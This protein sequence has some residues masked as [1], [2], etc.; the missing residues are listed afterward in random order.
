MSNPGRPPRPVPFQGDLR[1]LP[2]ALA[3]LKKLPNWVCWRWAWRIDKKGVGTWTKPPLQPKNRTSHARNNDPATWGTYAEALAVFET[4]KCDGIGFNLPGTDIAAFDIDKCRDPAT[5]DI[6]PEAMAIVNRATSYT[7]MTVSGTGLRVIGYGTGPKV[8]RKQKLPGSAVEV[9]SYRNAERYIVITGNP[10]PATWPHI[11]D[12][13]DVIDA[14]VAE[15]DGCKDGIDLDGEFAFKPQA[16]NGAAGD[17][18]DAFLPGDLIELIEKGVPP[19]DDLSAAFHHAV[20]WLADCGW[21]ADRIE[22][23]IAGKPIVPERFANRLGQE[24]ARCLH[25][26]KIKAEAEAKAKTKP[27]SSTPNQGPQGAGGQG[28]QQA[29]PQSGKGNSGAASSGGSCG[30][31]IDDFYAYMPDHSYIFVPTRELWPASSVNSRL[32]AVAVLKEDGTPALDKDGKP[33]HARPSVWLDNHR[34]VE[35][36][37]WMPG[38]PLTIDGRLIAEGG[39]VERPGVTTF[40]LYRPPVVREGNSANADR[41]VE[42]VERVYPDDAQHIITF[43]AHRIQC[44]AVKINHGLILGGAPGIGKDTILEPLKLG[45]GPWNFKEV[46]PQDIMSNYNDYMPSVVLRISEAHDL[47]DINRYAFYDHMKTILATPPDVIRVNAK[48]MPQ[49]Y[50]VNVAGVIY[51]T[52]HRFDGV[53]LPADDRRTY[54]AWSEVTSAEFVKEFWTSLYGWYG[55]GGR[56][57]VVAYLSE[58]D[59]SKFDP[60]APPRKTE[61]FWQIVGVGTAPEEAELKDILDTLGAEEK[62]RGADGKPCGPVVTTLGKVLAKA[63]GDLFEWLKDRKNRR[64]IPHRLER[65]GYT[66]VRNDGAKDRLWVINRK[67]QTVYGR[68]DAPLSDRVKAAQRLASNQ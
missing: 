6:A 47:G 50:V 41:W 20:C 21:S 24:I 55:A 17:T 9:E 42:L 54:V 52:N 23:R 19:Q 35:Q 68:M 62:A 40:N 4:G 25:K 14:V 56:E 49:Y 3:P 43:C 64:L 57:D 10:L 1:N 44:P 39:W 51:T 18:G 37:T 65:C 38:E 29:P 66:P 53:F 22:A 31:A 8:H 2:D 33:R 61:A 7:E 46:S 13:D 32:L 36:M 67:R 11:A 28:T 15:L 58:Y 16:G 5:G 34:P 45:V 30:V 60:K 27:G 63:E 26:R 59:L 12:I 48:Y